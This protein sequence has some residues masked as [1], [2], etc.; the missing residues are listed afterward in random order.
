MIRI[1]YQS[2]FAFD[3][4]TSVVLVLESTA[5]IFS[6]LE[7]NTSLLSLLYYTAS[8]LLLFES[9]TSLL[10]PRSNLGTHGN[11]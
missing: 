7:T 4:D 11:R 2:T 9:T 10:L 8:V 3:Y 6:L 5:S 1:Q